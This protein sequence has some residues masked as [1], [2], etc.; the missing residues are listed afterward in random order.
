[1]D[2]FF[3]EFG[4]EGKPVV[5]I[6]HGLL[7]SSR[8]WQAAAQ[9]LAKEHHVYCLDL[10][11]HGASPWEEPHSYEV[12]MEDV[13]V[14]MDENLDSRPILVGHSM[15]GKLAMKLACEYPKAIRKLVVVDIQ[16]HRY[17]NNHDDDFAGML[18]VDMDSLKSRTDAEAQLEP[19]VSSWAMRKFLLTN[20]EKDRVTGEFRWMV[21]VEAIVAGQRDIEE[22][23]LEPGDRYEGDT[24]FIM[25]GKSR[26]FVKDE[27]PQLRDYFPA[28]AL[29][30]IPES[31]HN[32]HFEC[33][34]RFVEILGAFVRS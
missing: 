22:N 32:P 10:R 6:L 12:M 19:H 34:E 5:V 13:M 29:E 2:L 1:M 31:G 8:N 27:V 18:A 3:R 9:A 14:W 20:L 4:D 28:S 21:N 24:L 33:R 25:G 16:P 23:P 15:G 17:P 26:Y 7:G 11:N 30:V